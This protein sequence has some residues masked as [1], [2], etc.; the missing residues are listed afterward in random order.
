MAV[1][2][3][4][5]LIDAVHSFT[6]LNW[7]ISIALSTVL[8]RCV[9]FTFLTLARKRV[10]G[11]CQDFEPIFELLKNAKDAASI[12]KVVDAGFPLVKKAGL[13][14]YL[15]TIVTPYTFI[16]TVFTLL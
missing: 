15:P 12:D 7:W 5:H 13:V 4:Q 3:V 2:A 6:G 11:M 14:V 8:L 9:V 10:F 16:T 1:A